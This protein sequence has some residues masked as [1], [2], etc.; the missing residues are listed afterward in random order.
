MVIDYLTHDNIGIIKIK[1]RI[2]A[3]NHFTLESEFKSHFKM[4]INNIIDLTDVEFIDSTG[5]GSLVICLK[6]SHDNGGVLK[7]CGLYKKVKMVF[8]ITKANKI[9]EIYDSIDAA[10][11]SFSAPP[12]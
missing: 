8:N 5:L 6:Y 11:S 10:I 1:G 4:A 9:F 3:S 12:S 2:D 7:L